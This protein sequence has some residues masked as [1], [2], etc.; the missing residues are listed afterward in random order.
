MQL[1]VFTGLPGT[2]KSSIAETVGRELAI[3]VFAKDWLEAVLVRCAGTATSAGEQQSGFVSYELLTTL[4]QRQLQL[5]QSAIL[6]SVASTETIRAAWRNLAATYHAGWCVI[7]CVCADTTVHQSRLTA[8]RR[9]IPGWPELT[10]AEVERVAGYYEPWQEQRLTL[11][12]GNLL[13]ANVGAARRYIQRVDR[14][15][16]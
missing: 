2:G 1:I 10:W 6:D 11:D 4:A 12:M 15:E 7:E 3:P 9:G 16:A 8:R 5:G 13:A 14:D